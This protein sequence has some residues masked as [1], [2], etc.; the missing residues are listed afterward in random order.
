[1]AKSKKFDVI[2]I[3][4]MAVLALAVIMAVVGICINW[5]GLTSE[6]AWTGNKSTD[7]SKLADLIKGNNKLG[8]KIFTGLEAIMAF[9]IITIIFSAVTGGVYV[10]SKFLDIKVLK[11]VIIALSVLVIVSALLSLILTFT[12][13]NTEAGK[14]IKEMGGKYAP[15]AGAWLLA[16]FG[17]AGGAAGVVGAVKN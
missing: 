7:Y 5:L 15:A 17:I 14:L 13:T 11:Y 2:S 8:S 1:M 10:L 12:C 3:V 16:I 6:N 9:G 4:V